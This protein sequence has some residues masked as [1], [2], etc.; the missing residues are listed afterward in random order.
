MLTWIDGSRAAEDETIGGKPAGGSG[1][2]CNDLFHVKQ[3][4]SQALG[5][6]LSPDNIGALAGRGF[7]NRKLT[8]RPGGPEFG[9]ELAHSWPAFERMFTPEAE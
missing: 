7:G 4:H 5:R 9:Q 3:P 6:P 8:R 1:F 2:D